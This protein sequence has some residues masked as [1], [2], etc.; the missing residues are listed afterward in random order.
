MSYMEK[1]HSYGEDLAFMEEVS[2]FELIGTLVK[3]DE[4]EAVRGSL[5]KEELEQLEKYDR[6]LL[7]HA[8]Q[9]YDLIREVYQFQNRKPLKYWWSN[10]D[11][12]A[13]GKLSVDLATTNQE[14]QKHMA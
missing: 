9:F 10:I 11:L 6:D 3:R 7:S 2:P 1:I 12:V 13:T 14:V 5:S 4:I 8:Q